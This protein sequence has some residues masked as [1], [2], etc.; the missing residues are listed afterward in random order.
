[1]GQRRQADLEFELARAWEELDGSEAARQA[2]QQRAAAEAEQQ[3]GEVQASRAEAAALRGELSACRQEA[4]RLRQLHQQQQAEHAA[5]GSASAERQQQLQQELAA[6]RSALAEQQA[7]LQAASVAEQEA[8]QRASLLTASLAAAKETHEAELA[9]ALQRSEAAAAAAAEQHAAALAPAQRE[10]DD[11]RQRLAATEAEFRCALQES[12][13]E[14]AGMRAD[15]EALAAECVEL[16]RT[17]AESQAQRQVRRCCRACR[18]PA[19]LHVCASNP[20]PH[21]RTSNCATM[22]VPGRVMSARAECTVRCPAAG[23]GGPGGRA[24]QRG[25]AAEAAPAG[26]GAGEGRGV[27]AA[28]GH[29]PA[30][31]WRP[32]L[33]QLMARHNVH[34][35]RQLRCRRWGACWPGFYHAGCACLWFALAP[36]HPRPA[37][38]PSPSAP[39][40]HRPFG[41]APQE[42]ERLRGELLALRERAGELAAVRDQLAQERRLT[43]SLQQRLAGTQQ[44][45]LEARQ[46]AAAR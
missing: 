29:E 16:R 4:E 36:T 35:L 20:Q 33:F 34:L 3:A 12:A 22:D 45:L 40:P 13:R 25:A 26:P 8:V 5:A 18:A 7:Q 46:G 37:L 2:E 28:A 44:Q 38:P 17:A 23:G 21:A 30:G 6:A 9:A 42:L 39:P 41:S 11:A 10:R 14:A 15:L 43:E 19:P 27:C 24:E 1:M 31:W 32:L